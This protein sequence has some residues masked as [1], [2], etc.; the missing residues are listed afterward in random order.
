L[1][2]RLQISQLLSLLIP[3]NRQ[4][5]DLLH[6][7]DHLLVSISLDPGQLLHSICVTIHNIGQI[8][9][10]F[11]L[12]QQQVL[13]LC[14]SKENMSIEETTR[15][16]QASKKEKNTFLLLGSSLGLLLQLGGLIFRSR[17]VLLQ[18]FDPGL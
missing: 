2:C 9:H 13:K 4:I 8:S 6:I 5:P 1:S 16:T 14:Q 15:K 10:Q 17:I 3:I 18:S 12:L 11:I 7:T